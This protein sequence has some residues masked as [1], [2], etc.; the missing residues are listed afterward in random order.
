ML[1]VAKN[2]LSHGAYAQ[3]Q[4]RLMVEESQ[5]KKLDIKAELKLGTYQRQISKDDIIS[6]LKNAGLLGRGGAGFCASTKWQAVADSQSVHRVVVANGSEGEPASAKDRWLMCHRP[7]LVLDG[8]L[9]AAQA[10]N[11]TRTIVYVSDPQAIESMKGAISELATADLNLTTSIEVFTAPAIYVA[12]EE[13]A[14][15]RAINGGLV[16]PTAKPP[17]P[18]QK[19]VDG[20]PTL[21]S[22]VETLAHAAW[23][24]RHGAEAF[25]EQ[26]TEDSPGTTLLTL[27]GDCERPGVY[28]VPLGLT[29]E[30]V[31]N[32][33][34]GGYINQPKA[35]LMGGWFGGI[36]SVQHA[37]TPCCYTQL[38]RAGSGLGCGAITV[39]NEQRNLMQM[40]GAIAAW[41]AS[42]SAQQ[43][44]TCIGGTQAISSTLVRIN[45]GKATDIDHT[46]LIRWGETLPGR[47]ACAFLDGAATL[48]RSVSQE[49]ESELKSCIE[50][51][52]SEEISAI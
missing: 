21:V 26:G 15:C 17:R 47:G 49:F 18:F 29:V 5:E 25:R 27:T 33:V 1:I 37:Q 32:T 40:A 43:C 34:G 24:S 4:P 16:K 19:G 22:N 45:R 14:V 23:I 42:E 2:A 8:L 51:S 52:K 38:R 7:H 10:L 50:M 35:F 44:G 9:L 41:Y 3:L 12:G 39:L 13:T 36:L 6:E 30:E 46:N 48:A 31:F 20:A 28:E 11:A